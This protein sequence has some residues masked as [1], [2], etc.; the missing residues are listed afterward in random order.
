M[1]SGDN[2]GGGTSGSTYVPYAST[3]NNFVGGGGGLFSQ[4]NGY[5]WLTA[6]LP[7]VTVTVD[8]NSGLALTPAGNAAFPGLTDSDLSAGPW[9]N[10][11]NGFSPIPT[12][13]TGTGNGEIRSV[14]IGGTGGS[15]TD[16][17]G[18]VPEPA[19]LA[20]LGIGM[21]GLVAMRRRKTA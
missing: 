19:S 3:I 2:I 1:D 14:I 17:G 20:L 6:L 4:A 21:A 10:W 11:F 5:Q 9:H 7:A 8:Q 18:T 15:I 13:A 12:L 16:P